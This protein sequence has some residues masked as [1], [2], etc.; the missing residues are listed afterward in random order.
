M[1]TTSLTTK[2]R[3]SLVCHGMMVVLFGFFGGMAW[4]MVLGEHLHLWPLPPIEANLPD[5]KELWRNA[6]TGPITNGIFAI[7]IAGI[8][9]LLSLSKKSARALHIS[10]I[11]MIWF[12]T[13]G[14]QVSP[15]T[16]NRGLNPTGG[17]IDSLCYFS[18]YIAVF[19]A[20]VT[21]IISLM[22]A[23]KTMKTPTV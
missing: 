18:F 6:H 16:T 8:G 5:T 4:I 21:V 17:V 19:G 3:A 15:F 7:A 14:Y 2:Q 10:A 23:Y 12:N 20:F 9:P 1:K 13:I 22:G 11:V